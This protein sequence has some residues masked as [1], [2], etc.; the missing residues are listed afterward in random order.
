MHPG[1]DRA[2]GILHADRGRDHVEPVPRLLRARGLAKVVAFVAEIPCD[3]SR[4]MSHGPHE[5]AHETP[6]PHERVGIGKQILALEGAREEKPSAH[7]SRHEGDHQLDVVAL[8]RVAEEPEPCHGARIQ[9]ERIVHGA[10]R[11]FLEAF[12]GR[13]VADHVP[14]DRLELAPCGEHAHHL[15]ADGGQRG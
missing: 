14:H 13:A 8:C 11:G 10:I 9:P 6:L 12:V 4:M 1:D 7:P 5:T 2:R 15:H 3:D